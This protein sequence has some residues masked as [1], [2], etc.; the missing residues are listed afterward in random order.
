[1][2]S[3][4]DDAKRKEQ[5]D[6]QAAALQKNAEDQRQADIQRDLADKKAYEDRKRTYEQ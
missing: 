2:N 6:R 1:M 3:N 5:S 4:D